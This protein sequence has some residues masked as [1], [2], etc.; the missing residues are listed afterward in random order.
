[1]NKRA[2]PIAYLV[3]ENLRPRTLVFA[4]SAG[5]VVAVLTSLFGAQPGWGQVVLFLLSF[6]I[7]AG[8]ISNRSASTRHFWRQ[9]SRKQLRG[10]LVTQ[11]YLD[12]RS[13]WKRGIAALARFFQ[14]VFLRQD[15]KLR[16]EPSLGRFSHGYG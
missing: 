4:A 12:I 9:R 15:E 1:M 14:K 8:W 16:S 7:A 3:G 2:S 11:L 6:D 13:M 10:A 5:L